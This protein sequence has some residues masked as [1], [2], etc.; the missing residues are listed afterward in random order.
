[1]EHESSGINP[2]QPTPDFSQ[3]QSWPEL[4][5]L[6]DRTSTIKGPEHVHNAQDLHHII[7]DVRRGEKPLNAITR[8]GGLREAVHRLIEESSP[9]YFDS[10]ER[11]EIIREI[12]KR[13]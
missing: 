5:E 11:F 10:N 9:E 12:K 6:I 13:E 8:A 3:V 7:D 1:M 2:E 4:H